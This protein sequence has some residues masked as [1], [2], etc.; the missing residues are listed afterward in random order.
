M[1]KQLR[2]LKEL[3][4][5]KGISLSKLS[6]ILKEKYDIS[7]ST[8]QLMYYEKGEREPRNKQVWEKLADYFNVSVSYLLGY[9]DKKE[10]YYSDEILLDNGSGGVSS[11]SFER[12]NDLQKEY[13]KQIRKDFINFLR[14]YDF[15]I[16]DNEIKVLLE[17]ISNLNIS[18]LAHIDHERVI[19]QTNPK[20]YLIE[21]G[22]KELG[23]LFQS[24][25]GIENFYK[26]KGYDPE[27]TL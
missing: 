18:T 16:S 21:N 25:K 17:Q 7:V 26:E 22:Y 14:S 13:S 3:R 24:N 10:P 8:S 15:V 23:D 27:S 19:K 4:Q 2:R 20:K 5:E 12:H 11:L 6:K 1:S 9:S